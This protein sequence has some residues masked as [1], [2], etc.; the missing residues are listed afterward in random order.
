MRVYQKN[1]T[2]FVNKGNASFE[3]MNNLINYVSKQVF[4]KTGIK[5][6]KEIKILK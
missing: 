1:T 4:D 2:I 6:E 3:D 5:I